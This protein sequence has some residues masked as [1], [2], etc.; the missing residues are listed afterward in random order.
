M[1][2]EPSECRAGGALSAVTHKIRSSQ[3]AATTLV[4]PS[5]F[6]LPTGWLPFY[7]ALGYTHSKQR[8]RKD[9]TCEPHAPVALFQ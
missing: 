7:T 4:A 1:S 2:S 9:T 8:H 6:S 3:A 5:P